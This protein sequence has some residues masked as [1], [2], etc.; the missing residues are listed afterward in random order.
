MKYMTDNRN[1]GKS[2][3]PLVFIGSSSEGV[4]IAEYLQHGLERSG[5]CSVVC[6]HQ[7][8]FEASSYTIEGLAET[9]AKADFA[10]LIATADDTVVTRGATHTV[11]RDNVIFELGLFIGALGRERT[12][13]VADEKNRLTLPS[14]LSGLT[15]LPYRE[16]D[17]KNMQAA[18]NSA[19][20]E[21]RR[22]TRKHGM[23]TAHAAQDGAVTRGR[24]ITEHEALLLEVERICVS[25]RAQGWRVKTNS[26]TTFRLVNREGRHFTLSIG[27]P[28][29]TRTELRRF[30]TQ[31]RAHGLRVNESVRRPVHDAPQ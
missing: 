29:R 17:D 14:D 13:V 22:L 23:R 30:A 12:Y 31:L 16:R 3:M 2:K 27:D 1:G 28:A 9:A 15:W 26:S 25:A 7:G 8:V 5:E 18:V 10:V 4:E 11:A 20:I 19:M 6:W 21:I 24:N